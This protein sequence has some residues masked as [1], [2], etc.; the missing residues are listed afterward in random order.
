METEGRNKVVQVCSTTPVSK[1]YDHMPTGV[2]STGSWRHKL[3]EA[4]SL[5]DLKQNQTKN[6]ITQTP[7]AKV[8]TK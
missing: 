5:Q 1:K 2:S 7:D 6:T 4:L 8:P 3:K